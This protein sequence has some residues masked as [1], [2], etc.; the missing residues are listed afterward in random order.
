LDQAMNFGDKIFSSLLR[1]PNKPEKMGDQVYVDVNENILG[2]VEWFLG[3]ACSLTLSVLADMT[4]RQ[5]GLFI[6]SHADR[7]SHS[8]MSQLG[9]IPPLPYDAIEIVS[10]NISSNRFMKELTKYPKIMSSDA[11]YLKDIGKRITDIPV[12]KFD[13]VHIRKALKAF[14]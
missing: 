13:V 12:D 10:T 11:H 9:Y 14:I 7:P 3:T 2:E 6:P 8:L 5:G 4:I 1:I